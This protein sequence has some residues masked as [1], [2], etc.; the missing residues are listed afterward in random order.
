MREIKF[1]AKT[2]LTNK[3]VYGHYAFVDG[4]HVIYEDEKPLI[5]KLNTIGQYTGLKDKNKQE[6]YEGHIVKQ[7]Y[8]DVYNQAETFRGEVVYSDCVYWLKNGEEYAFLYDEY[9][10]Y[11]TEI[12]G[13]V[14]ENPEIINE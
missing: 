6:I 5:I 13:S 9:R 10:L 14:Y 8:K 1:R 11:G 2:V 3:W 4:Y 7:S 12:I